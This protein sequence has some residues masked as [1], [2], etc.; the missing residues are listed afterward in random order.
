MAF[1][2]LLPRDVVR[3]VE[4][5]GATVLAG[6]PPLWVQLAEQEWGGRGASLRT[7]TNSGGHMPEPLVRRLRA[8]FPEARLHLMYGLTEAFRSASLDP[9][10]GRREARCG[11]RRHS[12]CRA[13]GATRGRERGGAW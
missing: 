2:Y 13:V 1:D 5:T 4:R 3:A 12:L 8:L 7:L 9:G 11:G 10:A 6:V